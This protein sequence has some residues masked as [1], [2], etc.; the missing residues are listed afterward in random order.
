MRTGQA[1]MSL[2]IGLSLAAFRAQEEI[3][4]FYWRN[5][6][7]RLRALAQC[8]RDRYSQGFNDGI[9]VQIE[10]VAASRCAFILKG[11]KAK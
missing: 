1:F 6:K 3:D 11:D 5:L 10:R 4:I 7:I 2:R 9:S 8:A